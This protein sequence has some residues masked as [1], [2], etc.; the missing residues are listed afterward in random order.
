MK[1]ISNYLIALF[2]AAN[3]IACTVLYYNSVPAWQ[4][5]IAMLG[6]I[7]EIGAFAILFTVAKPQKLT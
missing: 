6:L 5:L 3:P 4:E 1:N 2:I 7:C